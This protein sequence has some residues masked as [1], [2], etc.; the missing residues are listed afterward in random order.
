MGSGYSTSVL[1]VHQQA[2][3]RLAGAE[4][5][6]FQDEFWASLCGSSPSSVLL[7]SLNPAEVDQAIASH[8]T[9]LRECGTRNTRSASPSMPHDAASPSMTCMRPHHLMP[10]PS[11]L[12]PCHC[13][14][15]VHNPIT[16]NFQKLV[17]H[18]LDQLAA[19]QAGGIGMG[20]QAGRSSLSVANSVHLISLMVKLIAEAAS[21][22]T[23][24]SVFEGGPSLPAAAAGAWCRVCMMAPM[25]LPGSGRAEGKG[26]ANH[27]QPAV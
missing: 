12:Q 7:S 15:V 3:A 19:A 2:L 16:K 25:A 14:T 6:A 20:A 23:L 24:D 1:G 26:A 13:P 4:P 21:P 18:V 5:I 10:W 9:Q 22:S 17:L 11:P 27:A 8:C